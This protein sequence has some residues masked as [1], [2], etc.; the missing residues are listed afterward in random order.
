MQQELIRRNKNLFHIY[1]TQHR[2][3][4]ISERFILDQI[5]FPNIVNTYIVVLI[6]H[7]W[8]FYQLWPENTALFHKTTL[9][10]LQAAQNIKYMYPHQLYLVCWKCH[11]A[12]SSI[13][14][15]PA[16]MN[17]YMYVFVCSEVHIVIDR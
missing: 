16:A 17:T 11:Q 6:F 15:M 3:V 1:G 7:I 12:D 5:R 4:I 13:Y 9:N 14:Y 8:N 10:D 2:F